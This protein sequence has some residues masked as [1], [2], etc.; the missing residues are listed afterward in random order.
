MVPAAGGEAREPEPG[1]GGFR[2][3][4]ACRQ[5]VLGARGQHASDAERN[6]AGRG[7]DARNCSRLHRGVFPQ[8]SVPS[9][10]CGLI[11][12]CVVV[13]LL[14]LAGRLNAQRPPIPID[15]DGDGT[16]DVEFKDVFVP[17]GF[18]VFRRTVLA[19]LGSNA[20]LIRK[21]RLQTSYDVPAWRTNGVSW[22]G[23]AR[24][25][26]VFLEGLGSEPPAV[27][28]VH[29]TFIV[30]GPIPQVVSTELIGGEADF[31]DN[32]VVLLR[33]GTGPT[34]RNAWISFYAGDSFGVF[35]AVGGFGVAPAPG[36]PVVT[37]ADSKFRPL[38]AGLVGG[39]PVLV[40]DPLVQSQYWYLY[41]AGPDPVK[42]P[43]TTV[44]PSTVLDPAAAH[45]FIRWRWRPQ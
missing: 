38:R 9:R 36:S 15:V 18:A 23:V 30:A 13:F 8:A 37:G 4:G 1:V 35:V 41:E 31:T 16:A 19:P 27:D 28:L 17:A 42:G 24:E 29:H 40:E 20:V 43:W 44:T 5:A 2:Q 12:A 39:K 34:A 11:R 45:R 25:G 3:D 26:E 22:D 6:A 21:E 10:V 14:G 33:L 32:H 7:L